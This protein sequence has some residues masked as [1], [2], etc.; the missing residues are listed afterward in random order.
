MLDGLHEDV[1]LVHTKPL[2]EVRESDGRADHVIAKEAWSDHLLR[3]QSLVV[4][5]FHGQVGL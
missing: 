3:N 4:D 5:F 1:N 2:V